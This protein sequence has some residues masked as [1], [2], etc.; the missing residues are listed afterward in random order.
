M[1]GPFGPMVVIS[2]FFILC[3]GLTNV[4]SNNATAVLFTPIAVSAARQ[5]GIDEHILVLTVIFGSNCSFATP[6]I[7]VLW[8]AYSIAEPF[9]FDL[10]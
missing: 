4:L 10:N 5:L 9:Y 6:L 7:L 3:A 2:A 8:I 1:A